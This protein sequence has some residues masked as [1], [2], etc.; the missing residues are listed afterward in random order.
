MIFPRVL[1]CSW[2]TWCWWQLQQAMTYQSYSCCRHHHSWSTLLMLAIPLTGWPR[3]QQFTEL[4]GNSAASE[5]NCNKQNVCCFACHLDI[6]VKLLNFKWTVLCTWEWPICWPLVR[7]IIT[8][9][10][11]ARTCWKVSLWLWKSSGIVSPRPLL[12]GHRVWHN[13]CHSLPSPALW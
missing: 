6:C 12:G 7:V 2:I 8:V 11:C 1:S 9:S 3:P 4:S 13:V 10:F 5:K